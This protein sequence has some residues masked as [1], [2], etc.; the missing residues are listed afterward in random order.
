MKGLERVKNNR[1][2][3][4]FPVLVFY[5]GVVADMILAVAE[6]A[7][8]AAAVAELQLGITYIGA[9]ADGAAVT[10]SGFCLGGMILNINGLLRCVRALLFGL[11]VIA[12]QQVQ[13]F[14]SKKQEIIKHTNQRG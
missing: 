7:I 10:V 9:A 2:R 1:E 8:A 13:H 4:S 14:F 6:V 11:G 12:G 5:M 3:W